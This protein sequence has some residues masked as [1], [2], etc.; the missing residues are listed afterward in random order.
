MIFKK[1]DY[2]LLFWLVI[3]DFFSKYNRTCVFNQLQIGNAANFQKE[4]ECVSGMCCLGRTKLRQIVLTNPSKKFDMSGKLF[5]KQPLRGV[6]ENG[7]L[8]F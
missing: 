5:W 2:G 1:S 8:K 7:V 6:V 4:V 3:Q